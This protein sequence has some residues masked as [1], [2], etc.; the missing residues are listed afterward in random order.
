[1]GTLGLFLI[2]L[3]IAAVLVAGCSF[4]ICYALGKAGDSY[5]YGASDSDGG[6]F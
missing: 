1:M 5:S 2:G 6:F 4:C 3:G